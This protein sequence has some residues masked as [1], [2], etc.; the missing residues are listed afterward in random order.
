MTK[1]IIRAGLIGSAL[2]FGAL[3]SAGSTIISLNS[4]PVSATFFIRDEPTLVINGF[5]L[6]SQ[7]L[8][9]P[10]TI[11]AI[12]IDVARPVAGQP[13][14][15]VVY[16]DP[17]G[18]SPQDAQLIA[19]ADVAVNDA[20]VVRIPL[21]QPV[22]TS[23]PI[24]WAGFYLPV[25][26]R[27]RADQSGNSVLTYWG[28]TPNSVID[29]GNLASAAV[30]GPG[31]G[32]AP[33][34]IAM[35]GIARF[36]LELTQADG[37][38]N[39]PPA[40][41][42]A[43]LGQQIV[44]EAQADLS[45][46]RSYN[47]CPNLRYDPADISITAGGTFDLYCRL[48]PLPMQPGVIGNISQVPPSIPSFERRGFI[49]QVAATGDYQQTPTDAQLLRVPV[50]HCIKPDAADIGRAVMGV[51]H[52]VPQ[53]WFILPTQRYGEFVCAEL[54]HVGPV[55][56]FV[57]RTGTEETLNLDLFGFLS[58]TPSP[59]QFFCK[60]V[61][62]FRWSVKNDGFEAAPRYV[63]RLV[64]VAVRTGQVTATWETVV[65]GHP[66]GDTV[67]GE[68]QLRIPDTFINEANRLVLQ[69]DADNNIAELNEA[70]NTLIVDYI[71][72]ARAGGCG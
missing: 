57:P 10:V 26:F 66:P 5:D 54:T 24:V 40:L 14:T 61:I 58:T 31:D 44:T 46:L 8:A 12:T 41:G 28:W 63:V 67:S 72:K 59:D 21:P 50:T 11:D 18:G 3:T 64:N 68:G 71:L 13:V 35:G 65:N 4:G 60:D 39:T 62:T 34:N 6:G 36:T 25:D 16:A 69:I 29:L 56:Y 2:M 47:D 42:G 48:E 32:S 7:G 17:N 43:P 22:T 38:T 70:N 23:S 49:Y 37:R 15:L 33:V 27:F 30:F 19:R 1:A 9:F 45:L 53:Q 55:A 51:A 52:S 20:G